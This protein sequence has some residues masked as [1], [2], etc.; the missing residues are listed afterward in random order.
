MNG[1]F[2][3]VFLCVFHSENGNIADYPLVKEISVFC[4][5]SVINSKAVHY[6]RPKKRPAN[7]SNWWLKGIKAGVVS[8]SILY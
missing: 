3:I 6:F 4:F 2:F 7:L 5:V 8:L 1:C